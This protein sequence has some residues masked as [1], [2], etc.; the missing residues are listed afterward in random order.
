[1]NK[2]IFDD[3]FLLNIQNS[4][5]NC[6]NNGNKLSAEILVDIIRNQHDNI[7]PYENQ[8]IDIHINVEFTSNFLHAYIQY[9]LK[10]VDYRNTI[11]KS[12]IYAYN[13]SLLIK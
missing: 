2:R 10:F 8:L 3:Q 6:I 1:M 7:R 5:T 4:I 9:K 13:K 12:L 11:D